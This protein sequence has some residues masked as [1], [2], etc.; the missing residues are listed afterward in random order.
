MN[1]K[2]VQLSSFI[3]LNYVKEIFF[4]LINSSHKKDDLAV[5]KLKGKK[6]I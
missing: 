6:N 3:Q 2:P 4:F 5:C 1:L